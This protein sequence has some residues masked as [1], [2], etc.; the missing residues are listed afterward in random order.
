MC[1]ETICTQ[2]VQTGCVFLNEDLKIAEGT[3]VC[4]SWHLPDNWLCLIISIGW[5][6][7]NWWHI[8]LSAWV[9][10]YFQLKET[11]TNATYWNNLWQFYT[12]AWNLIQSTVLKKNPTL[13]W[14]IVTK[15]WMELI[16][17][18]SN[19]VSLIMCINIKRHAPLSMS[20][21]EQMCW[22]HTDFTTIPF[23]GVFYGHGV[24]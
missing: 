2:W 7:N 22:E 17:C 24:F 14:M 11:Q 15:T 5:I 20:A 3:D 13:F 12:L 18:T 4:K 9:L 1:S 8:R 21:D 6:I 16:K 19:R 23:L 10:T